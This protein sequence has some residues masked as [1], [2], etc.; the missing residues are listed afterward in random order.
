VGAHIITGHTHEVLGEVFEDLHS[1]LTAG[2][3]DQFLAEVVSIGVSEQLPEVFF[4]LINDEFNDVERSFLHKVL[5]LQ[6]TFVGLHI[7]DDLTLEGVVREIL[8]PTATPTAIRTPLT[9]L[10]EELLLLLLVELLLGFLTE[11][12]AAP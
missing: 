10:E 11:L 1:L 9:L 3:E 5:H 2:T 4:D 6:R 12:T 7:G 8:L